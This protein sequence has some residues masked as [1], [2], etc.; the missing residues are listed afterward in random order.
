MSEDRT[1]LGD[2]MKDYEGI[3]RTVLPRR[4]WT[5][6]RLDGRNFHAWTR[7]LERP[8]SAELA[9]AID[10]TALALCEQVAGTVFAYTQSDEVSLLLTDFGKVG[11]QPWFGG[12][13]Q[14]MTSI[15]ASIATANFNAAMPGRSPAHFDSRVFT[16]PGSGEAANY[17]IWR[18]RDA[19]RNSV[20]MAA[21]SMFSHQ[22]LHGVG[23]SA[24][25]DRM[26]EAGV[27]WNDYP[28]RFKRGGQVVKCS[29]LRDVT[30]TDK[31][32][33]SEQTITVDR[34][35]WEIQDADHYVF[36]QL[37]RRLAASPTEPP[38][39]TEGEA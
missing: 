16:V 32:T 23:V 34:S 38:A 35:W 2:R 13:V 17:F 36:E 29:G 28:A 37:A 10:A 25:Q 9:A 1:A 3:T 5:I 24:M 12:S 39:P 4:A 31:R 19:V 20:A 26:H 30:Y 27:N 14:K 33:G 15:S 8:F 6:M 22:S 21:Q 11:T 18:Q 7:G